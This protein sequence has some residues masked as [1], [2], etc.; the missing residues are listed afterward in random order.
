MRSLVVIAVV[1]LLLG[2]ASAEA[3]RADDPVVRVGPE[4]VRGRH[5]MVAG[6]DRFLGIPYAAP[7]VGALRWREPQ[8]LALKTGTIDAGAYAPS[9]VQVMRPGV[10][11]LFPEIPNERYSE[12]CLY[13]NVW[14]P[15]GKP[16]KPMPV[17]VWLHGGGFMEGSGSSPLNSGGRLGA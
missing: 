7:P 4:V 2:A 15:A 14:K 8:P 9:C 12:D 3:A 11:V 5:D 10:S 17:I 16:A 1:S 13:L 6:V